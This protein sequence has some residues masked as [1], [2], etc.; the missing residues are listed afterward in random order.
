VTIWAEKG[1]PSAGLY[2]APAAWLV[3]TQLN[4]SLV[5]WICASDVQLVP[6]VA[7]G[8]ALVSLAAGYLSWRAWR[9][10]PPLPSADDPG[11]ARPHRLV[12]GVGTLIAVLFTLVIL[13]Q[14]AAGLV[15]NGCER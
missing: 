14:G 8:F 1:L 2:G 5:S 10:S 11:S 12:A 9:S 15:F 7:L 6:L 13:L 3:N 4:Y